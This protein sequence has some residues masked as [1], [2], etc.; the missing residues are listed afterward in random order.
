[1]MRD[2]Q[3]GVGSWFMEPF[4]GPAWLRDTG[5]RVDIKATDTEYVINAEV[6]GFNKE[7]LSLELHEDRLILKVEN[8]QDVEEKGEN[9]LR[10]E[11]GF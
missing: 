2:F 1:M 8:R 7:D 5:P 3:R 10:R 11:R 6:P 9:Y 4:R